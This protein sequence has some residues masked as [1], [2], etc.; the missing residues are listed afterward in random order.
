MKIPKVI[1]LFYT[2]ASA[3]GL[4]AAAALCYLR[5]LAAPEHQEGRGKS[6][7]E[8]FVLKFLLQGVAH[9]A[10]IQSG[11]HSVQFWAQS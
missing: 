5:G 6:G 7:K 11:C 10:Q 9:T 8:L 2:A 4:E 3:R 1:F